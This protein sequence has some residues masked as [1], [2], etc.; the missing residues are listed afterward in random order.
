MSDMTKLDADKIFLMYALTESGGAL[1][2]IDEVQRLAGLRHPRG[3]GV[4]ARENGTIFA[5]IRMALQFSAN[6][7][8]VFWPHQN[9]A[10]RGARLRQSVGLGDNHRSRAASFGTISSTWTRGLTIGPL[11]RHD[12]F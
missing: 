12:R 5:A 4:E 11:P 7:S 6:V 2:E 1:R 3:P 9:G 10:A 8:K